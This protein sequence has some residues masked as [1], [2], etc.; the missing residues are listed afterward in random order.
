MA[1][2]DGWS[3]RKEITITG[4]SGAGTDFQV[5][6]SIGDSANGDFH[7]EGNC[8]NFPEDIAVTDSDE[9]TL[10]DFWIEDAAADPIKMWVE[11]ADDLGSNQTIYVYYGKSGETTDSNGDNTFLQYEGA[12]SA[13]TLGALN[14]NAPYVYEGYGRQTS[15]VNHNI[16]FGVANTND[17]T[18]DGTYMQTHYSNNLRYVY[19]RNEGAATTKSETPDFG[20]DAYHRLKIINTG[21]AVTGL[22]GGDQIG[23]GD[24]TTNLPDESMG[25]LFLVASGTGD[26]KWAFARKYNSPEPSFSSAGS[27][28]TPITEATNL[29]H[30]KI[31]IKDSSIILVDGLLQVKDSIISLADGK[32]QVRDI[33]TDLTD[34]KIKVQDSD[35]GL[36]D[37]KV[38]VKDIVTNLADGKVLV[39]TV[40]TDTDQADGKIQI[41]DVTTGIVDGLIQIKDTVVGLADGKIRVKDT[42]TNVVDGILK[43]K[44]T[45]TDLADGKLS[46]SS[47]V[48]TAIN[49]FNGLL[50]IPARY[51]ITTSSEQ[52]HTITFINDEVQYSIIT[53]SEPQHNIVMIRDEE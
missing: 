39:T 47:A 35:T 36:T 19:A 6:F 37:G 41:K 29:L 32:V 34:G 16:L 44:D 52:Q 21:S 26:M 53:S 45:I 43:I 17:A 18:D 12:I 15:G 40:I 11:V 50:Q 28:E 13:T 2:L 7:L 23:T 51:H 14:I 5:P 49:L 8:T 4:Q 1:W 38:Q 27:E 22:I 9:T 31:I 42:V 10:L 3:Y 46:I 48:S 24:I 20:V 33:D 25:L 30:G